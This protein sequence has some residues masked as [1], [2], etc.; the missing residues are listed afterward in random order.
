MGDT[1]SILG[2]LT[3]GLFDF[4]MGERRYER[5]RNDA[6]RDWDRQNAYNAPKA[7]MERFKEAGLNPNLIYGQG[8]PGNASATPLAAQKSGAPEHKLDLQQIYGDAKRL[9]MN[10]QQTQQTVENLK[11][12]QELMKTN[13]ELNRELMPHKISS[14]DS[15]TD[16]RK[17]ILEPTIGKINMG[18]GR[19]NYLIEAGRRNLSLS[20]QK[21][22]REERLLKST[23]SLNS[24]RSQNLQAQTA[25]TTQIRAR[26]V[27]ETL[28]A[29][30]K[31]R[32]S[33]SKELAGL[34]KIQAETQA[35]IQGKSTSM[36]VEELNKVNTALKQYQTGFLPLDKFLNII[37]SIK[38]R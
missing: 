26:Q 36:S 34:E 3:G 14:L 8:T 24:D 5:D 28:I 30:D 4:M 17:G 9:E 6:N 32:Y 23:L 27:Y 20:E 11:T 10:M 13:M 16:Y 33:N 29:Q 31:A 7:Q 1:N 12:N 21:S 35:I 15:Q 18:I 37:N 22:D 19:D 38:T 2:G 25:L